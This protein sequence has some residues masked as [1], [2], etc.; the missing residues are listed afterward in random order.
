MTSPW[1]RGTGGVS[2]TSCAGQGG[3]PVAYILGEKGFLDYTFAVTA[4]TLIPRPETE[5]LVEKILAV[6]ADGPLD[7]LELGV[8]SGA[9]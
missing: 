3:K 4:D 8:G 2:T 7:I 9:F 5:L 6:T 1:K